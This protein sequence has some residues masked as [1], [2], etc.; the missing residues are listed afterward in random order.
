VP[1]EGAGELG[2]LEIPEKIR[3]EM[4]VRSKDVI[5]GLQHVVGAGRL[6][7]KVYK[8]K[9]SQMV[10]PESTC[11][12]TTTTPNGKLDLDGPQIPLSL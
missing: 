4:I 5:L 11:T 7:K 10:A 12:V 3:R 1:I 2:I 6:Y 9:P 8:M